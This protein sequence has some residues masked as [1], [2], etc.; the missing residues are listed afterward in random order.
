[1]RNKRH[2]HMTGH[3]AGKW[4]VWVD[5]NF[6]YMDPDKRYLA[7][8]YDT[9]RDAVAAACHIINECLQKAYT[10]GMHLEDIWQAYTS[11]GED[12]WIPGS[13]FSAWAYAWRQCLR[14]TGK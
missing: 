9:C 2:A 14:L 6:L 13:P 8:E 11:F 10:P 3:P 12:P 7:G 4:Q 1:M 5:D